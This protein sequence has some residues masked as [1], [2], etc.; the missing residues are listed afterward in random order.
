MMLSWDEFDKE[1]SDEYAVY[2]SRK[3]PNKCRIAEMSH[4]DSEAVRRAKAALDTLD[5]AEEAYSVQTL[6]FQRRAV[7]HVMTI[8][9]TPTREC[10]ASLCTFQLYDFQ[11]DYAYRESLRESFN[12]IVAIF[13]A[14]LLSS[15]TC[16]LI[17]T[18]LNAKL[19]TPL[20]AY[21]AELSIDRHR[22]R[23]AF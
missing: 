12:K 1:L 22:L 5:A 17:T 9:P 20:F 15:K 8:G 21:D 10:G 18:A 2:S 4:S 19:R 6:N 13:A 23:T 14:Y 11:D 3:Q 16:S 7:S